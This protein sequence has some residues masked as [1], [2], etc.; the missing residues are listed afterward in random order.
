[1]LVKVNP[2]YSG[3]YGFFKNDTESVAIKTRESAP[4]EEDD[5]LSLK[6]IGKGVLVKADAPEPVKG[7]TGEKAEAGKNPES[8]TEEDKGDGLEAMSLKELKELAKD[9][10]V[11]YKVGMSKASLIDAIVKAQSEEPPVLTAALPE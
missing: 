3:M 10:G 7:E 8:V 1:M 2:D 4:F 9:C 6:M 11:L 5:A